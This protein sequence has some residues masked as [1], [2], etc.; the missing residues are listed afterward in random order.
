M[1]TDEKGHVSLIGAGPGDPELITVRAIRHLEQADIVFHDK[2]SPGELIE[3][4]CD[5]ETIVRDV[6]KRKGKV[7]PDQ[8]DINQDLLEASRNH[9]RVVRLKGGDPYLFGRGGEE[10]SYL[11]QHD[12]PF[13]VIP[14]ISSLLAVP[15]Y[16]GVPATQRRHSSSMAVFTGHLGSRDTELPWESLS[17]IDTLIAM[18]GITRADEIAGHLVDAGRDPDTPV[19]VVGWGTTP[20]Q[21]STTMTLGHLRD[22]IDNER[23]Y[24]PGL[25]IIGEVVND[26]ETLN[27][28]ENRPLF[29][30]QIV[31]T[32]PA[33]QIDGAAN[34]LRKR[35]AKP[36]KAPTI[37]IDPLEEGLHQL[38]QELPEL[39]QYDWLVF[40]SQNGVRFF[41][42]QLN[43]AGL[44][45]RA[46][47]NTRIATIGEKTAE[48]LEEH[49]CRADVVPDEYRAEALTSAMLE[50]ME[51]GDTVLLPRAAGARAHLPDTLRE[52]D[53]EVR[54]IECYQSVP[55][56]GSRDRLRNWFHDGMVDMI[57]FTSASTVD[58]LFRMF[59]DDED[60][61]RECLADTHIGTIGPITASHLDD[62]GI[63]VDVIPD[64][65]TIG[66]LVAAIEQFYRATSAK[67][68]EVTRS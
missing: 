59:A 21:Q 1:S 44:D 3:R 24:L 17:D 11:S 67:E 62:R 15:N 54:E 42:E 34:Q 60:K 37:N 4:Y 66:G 32:R 64:E 55:A 18:M 45:T 8:S 5:P 7:G 30:K 27:W 65:Y 61:L 13:E 40:T 29:G 38:D 19:A 20:E 26:R 39:E 53:H 16:A 35:G 9:D 23:D 46:L 41:F 52:R 47:G 31:L 48:S 14:G 49:G 50:E 43:E 10:A 36:L 51:S 25:L 12:V 2:L 6:G 57:T 28:Y 56:H 68:P 58:N 33:G 22:G 63:N